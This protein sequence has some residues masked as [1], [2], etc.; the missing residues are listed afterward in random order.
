MN[1]ESCQVFCAERD[2]YKSELYNE[3]ISLLCNMEGA[4]LL[5][6][7]AESKEWVHGIFR[8][9]EPPGPKKIAMLEDVIAGLI[10]EHG[11]DPGLWS[12]THRK[13][14]LGDYLKRLH[15]HV[16][17]I[18]QEQGRGSDAATAATAVLRAIDRQAMIT[19]V[20]AMFK[21]EAA[22]H[23]SIRAEAY[24]RF[25]SPMRELPN[26]NPNPM[27]GSQAPCES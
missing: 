24:A 10:G 11:L 15:H 26:P 5:Q 21:E 20:R 13:E 2:Q 4:R 1:L 17:S 23:Y 22:Q 9:Q 27:R 19:N 25:S 7:A 12:W 16:D 6:E 8:T 3:Q 18:V 14:Y